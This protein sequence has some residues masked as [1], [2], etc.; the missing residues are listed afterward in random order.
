M[1]RGTENVLLFL[2]G[3][4]VL[5]IAITGVYTRY[6][7]P[8]LLPWLFASAAVLIILGV[9][10]MIR[11]IRQFDPA[12]ESHQHQHQHQH[13]RGITWLMVV[14]I[15][16]LVFVAPPALNPRALS[17]SAAP[18]SDNTRKPFAALPP[19]GAPAIPLPEVLMRIA[20]GP[21]GG[22]DGRLITITGFTM[23]EADRVDL[24]KIVIVC[25]AAD[26]QLARL[27][28]SG[29]AV[30]VAAGLPDNTWVR[31]QGIVPAGQHYSGTSSIPTVEVSSVIPIPAP[32]NTY[33]S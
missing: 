30:S 11:D 24:A 19:G 16:V 26:A 23:K 12:A 28:L 21:A 15:V 32:A 2:L 5:M 4:S 29:S 3:V 17:G 18:L 6:V 7:R 22:I 1:R 8:A 14:P 10:A 20:V 31:V 9:S 27:H 25:C 33:G 13:G